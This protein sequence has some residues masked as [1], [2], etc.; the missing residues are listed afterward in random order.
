MRNWQGGVLTR[1]SSG[2]STWSGEAC[3][4]QPLRWCSQSWKAGEASALRACS[5]RLAQSSMARRC[6]RRC[7]ARFRHM[8]WH[9]PCTCQHTHAHSLPLTLITS[10]CL[11]VNRMLLRDE[12][13]LELL[14]LLLLLMGAIGLTPSCATQVEPMQIGRT[15]CVKWSHLVLTVIQKE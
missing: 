8:A 12:C 14:L 4:C 6:R 2:W 13:L 15:A 11:A 5:N 3:H 10:C 7:R 1:A 9:Q